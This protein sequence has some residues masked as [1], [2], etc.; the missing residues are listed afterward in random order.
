MVP[1]KQLELMGRASTVAHALAR[2]GNAERGYELL[3]TRLSLAR[4]A[5][6]PWHDELAALYESALRSYRTRHP[7]EPDPASH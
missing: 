7:V 5:A 4:D 1:R 6:D 3:L 2:A